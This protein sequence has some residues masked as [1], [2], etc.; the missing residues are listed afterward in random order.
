[1]GYPSSGL[2]QPWVIPAAGYPSREL[3]QRWVSPA[4]ALPCS[5]PTRA[6]E[7]PVWLQGGEPAPG[8]SRGRGFPRFPVLGQGQAQQSPAPAVVNLAADH[9]LQE[10][11]LTGGVVRLLAIDA[12]ITYLIPL[13]K[14][15]EASETAF[16]AAGS[17]CGG[18]SMSF[19]LQL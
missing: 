19:Y 14:R 5:I 10:S 17:P 16:W 12:A 8:A 18:R 11:H 15:S 4:A 2:S 13:L 9:T 3:F 7:P 1:M 6:P